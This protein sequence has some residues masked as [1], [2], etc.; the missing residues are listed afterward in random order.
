MTVCYPAGS[1]GAMEHLAGR[2]YKRCNFNQK[3]GVG[4]GPAH[5]AGSLSAHTP[6]PTASLPGPRLKRPMG[7]RENDS[8]LHGLCSSTS[9]SKN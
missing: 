2:K 6:E 1:L 4:A 3:S 9:R 7:Q 8:V 5:L